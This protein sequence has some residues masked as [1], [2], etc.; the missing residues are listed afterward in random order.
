MH[1]TTAVRRNGTEPRA[2]DA[3]DAANV[4]AQQLYV[5]L[6][7]QLP[8]GRKR[9]GRYARRV[10][11]MKQGAVTPT[12]ADWDRYVAA[13]GEREAVA[14]YHEAEA[15]RYRGLP[16]EDLEGCVATLARE[17]GEALALT[18]EAKRDPSLRRRALDEQLD[19]IPAARALARGLMREEHDAITTN[20]TALDRL[21][22]SAPRHG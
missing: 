1:A 5:H 22:T 17:T 12:P 11:L 18:L 9:L 6:A 4:H 16:L 19:V 10:K 21:R 15:A 7:D 2:R 20:A 8:G 13:G 3:H 14:T